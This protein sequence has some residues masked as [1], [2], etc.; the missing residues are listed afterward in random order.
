MAPRVRH[1]A[2]AAE[3]V[4]PLDD[5]D[6]R[7]DRITPARDA[8]RPR[9]VVV[10]I[11]I[12]NGVAGFLCPFHQQRQLTDSL[13]THNHVDDAMRAFLDAYAL[14]LRHTSGNSDDR[15]A[16]ELRSHLAQLAEPCKQLL[17]RPLADAAGVD[18]D[19]VGVGG[20]GSLF[21]AGLFEQPRHALGVVHVH[22][23][24]VG[25]DQILA[26]HWLSQLRC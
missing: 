1:D 8:Q 4:A 7:L 14:L 11:E 17:F 3:F 12:E 6:V 19:H 22:L 2:E 13:R 9:H 24:A 15:I 26:R 5:R 16:P 10:G 25:F 23:A 20:V 18:D 21:E